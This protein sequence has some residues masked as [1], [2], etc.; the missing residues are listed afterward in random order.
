MTIAGLL[1]PRAGAS[2][3]ERAR[4]PD[5]RG[6]GVVIR[7]GNVSRLQGV[8]SVLYQHYAI[9]EI[10]L[11][12]YIFTN[13]PNKS[14]VIDDE[15][16]TAHDDHRTRIRPHQHVAGRHLYPVQETHARAGFHL[17]TH[18]S[19]LAQGCPRKGAG[20]RRR[21]YVFELSRRRAG[22]SWRISH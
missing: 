3:G 22:Q 13:C 21:G 2:V 4:P 12:R 1:R 11:L 6:I 8:T 19:R 7:P 5:E 17:Q 20:G 10:C 16:D 14:T 15:S 18:S 9:Y